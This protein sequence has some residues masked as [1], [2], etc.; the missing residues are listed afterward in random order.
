MKLKVCILLI[1]LFTFGFVIKQAIS[2]HNARTYDSESIDIAT[3]NSIPSKLVSREEVLNHAL[4][5][6]NE[7]ISQRSHIPNRSEIAIE[8]YLALGE[9]INS[10][11]ISLTT[12]DMEYLESQLKLL[13]MYGEFYFHANSS[14]EKQLEDLREHGLTLQALYDTSDNP[15]ENL[16]HCIDT[17]YNKSLQL[18]SKEREKNRTAYEHDS[19]KGVDNYAA[20]I[21]LNEAD[22]KFIYSYVIKRCID[23]LNQTKSLTSDFSKNIGFNEKEIL[24]TISSIPNEQLSDKH[25]SFIDELSRIL[26]NGKDDYITNEKGIVIHDGFEN[27]ES[28]YPFLSE[29]YLNRRE[30]VSM[31]ML[32][33][34]K[35]N[36]LTFL[37]M[38]LQSDY[39]KDSSP[40]NMQR[41]S[42]GYLEKILMILQN[43]EVTA[44]A[45]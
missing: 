37:N 5:L 25:R 29:I 33:I 20:F 11:E 31:S 22:K 2:S 45:S 27:I 34:N 1:V 24:D 30:G 41:L 15:A 19:F 9:L 38:K 21:S 18:T 39:L 28:K 43:S 26:N 32:Y 14:H 6:L 35:E 12:K 36:L 8:A 23:E 7:R 3:E 17:I 4:A 13:D 42:I 40:S 10:S 16:I 44:S